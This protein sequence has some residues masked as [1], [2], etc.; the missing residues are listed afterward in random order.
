MRE[1]SNLLSA[2]YQMICLAPCLAC[3]NYYV[4]SAAFRSEAFSAYGTQGGVISGGNCY[5]STSGSESSD[6]EDLEGVERVLLGLLW[7]GCRIYGDPY[8]WGFNFHPF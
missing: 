1:V 6:I 4:V 8:V 5:L 7:Q 3:K 2:A